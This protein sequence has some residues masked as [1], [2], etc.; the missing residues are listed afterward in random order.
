MFFELYSALGAE[1]QFGNEVGQ[2]YNAYRVTHDCLL[3]RAPVEWAK[4]NYGRPWTAS[5][6]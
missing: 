4:P 6:W 3:P 1:R 5:G 2:L